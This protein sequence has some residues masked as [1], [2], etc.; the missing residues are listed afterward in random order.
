MTYISTLLG[1]FY[2]YPPC[3]TVYFIERS[4]AFNSQL[5]ED[6]INEIYPVNKVVQVVLA[7][8][9]AKTVNTIIHCLV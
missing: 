6:L 7:L 9:H 5:E 3:C 4:E 1:W 8:F 2:G